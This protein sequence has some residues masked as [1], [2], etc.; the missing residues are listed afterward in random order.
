MSDTKPD[1]PIIAA[2][3]AAGMTAA[4]NRGSMES[5][6]LVKLYFD[7]LDMLNYEQK[8][9]DAAEFAQRTVLNETR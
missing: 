5:N 1:D 8:K 9:R 6:Q 4:F 2:T 3:L 7:L